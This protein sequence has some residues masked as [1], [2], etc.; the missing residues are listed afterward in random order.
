MAT[1]SY[2]FPPN[3]HECIYDMEASWMQT[4]PLIYK[5]K[6]QKKAV[7]R[8]FIPWNDTVAF[9]EFKFSFFCVLGVFTQC[10]LVAK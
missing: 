9:L 10:G 4:Q 6:Q 8:V 7:K 2:F 5:E 1:E 3:F